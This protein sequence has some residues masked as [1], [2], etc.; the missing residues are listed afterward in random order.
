MDSQHDDRDGSQAAIA[1]F[2]G[3]NAH[4][5]AL[6]FE[7]LSAERRRGFSINLAAA[8]V[9]PVWAIGRGVWTWFWIGA[10][11]EAVALIFI[12]RGLWGGAPEGEWFG[13]ELVSQSLILGLVLLVLVRGT[14]ALAANPAY[15]RR[16]AKW[17]FDRSLPSGISRTSVV[18]GIALLSFVYPLVAYRFTSPAPV[19]YVLTFPTTREIPHAVADGIDYTVDWMILHFEGFFTAITNVVRTILN[20]LELILVGTPWPVIT[21]LL[22]LVAWRV[23]GGK[24]T[25]FT[26]AA[27]AYLGLFGFW[28]KSMS[29]IALVATSV[30]I[31]V[32]FG[33]PL[34]IW[35]AKSPRVN[36]I[37]KPILDVMQTM[38]AFVYLIPAVAFFSIGKPPGVLATVIFAM[39]PMIRLT[40]LGIQQVPADVR[41]ATIAFGATPRQL[42]FKVEY[43]LAIPSI[44]T[45]INQTIMMSLSMV[46]VAALIGAGGLGYDVIRSLRH[47]ET[48]KGVMAGIA[49]VL[50]A[51]VLD[52]IIQS[53]R[54]ADRAGRGTG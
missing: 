1:T 41:E 43:P 38:P 36:F 48:G 21:L 32:V 31:C 15:R 42:L 47:L 23:A 45:G 3:P 35:C 44:M 52:R 20:F 2:V 54:K 5:Y 22:L 37:V 53:A 14:L 13:G 18:A 28:D 6:A 17:Q 46:V 51:M 50:C 19:K 30:L 27:L 39:P 7:R 16:F 25:V 29:T 40:T 11:G 24:V 9:G 34:G 8:F 49:I 4:Y 26:A 12:S 33:G 10:A